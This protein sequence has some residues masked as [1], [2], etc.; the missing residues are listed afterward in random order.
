[1]HSKTNKNNNLE[2]DR[3]SESV[4]NF[5]EM[6][7]NGGWPERDSIPTS[8]PIGDI[9]EKTSSMRK[10]QSPV[11][12]EDFRG[13]YEYLEESLKTK[14]GEVINLGNIGLSLDKKVINKKKERI[15][16][17]ESPD[18]YKNVIS[19]NLKFWSCRNCGADLGDL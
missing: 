7:K 10:S 15:F 2:H 5:V 19:K 8:N 13:L 18:K 12:I 14:K 1:M 3:K 11:D 16:C 4:Y 9:D 6:N 17:C